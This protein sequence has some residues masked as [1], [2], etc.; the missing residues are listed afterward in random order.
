MELQ[1]LALSTPATTRPQETPKPAPQ[2]PHLWGDSSPAC[3]G[4]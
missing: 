3:L 4:H 1:G 2:C